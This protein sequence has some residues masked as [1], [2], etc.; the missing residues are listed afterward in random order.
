MSTSL[1]TTAS[2]MVSVAYAAVL[3]R[4]LTAAVLPMLRHLEICFSAEAAATDRSGM[5]REAGDQR[6]IPDRQ[7][8]NTPPAVAEPR[9]S[10]RGWPAAFPVVGWWLAPRNR[11]DGWILA[12]GIELL[13]AGVGGLAWWWEVGWGMQLPPAF[14][15]LPEAR[16]LLFLRLLA[17]LT[18]G[19]FLAAATWCDLRYRVIPDAITVPGLLLGMAA[20]TC[21]PGLLLPIGCLLPTNS[22]SSLVVPDLLGPAG[23]LL[24]QA[25]AGL[26]LDP[27][28]WGGL[29]L[30]AAGFVA[31]WSVGTAAAPHRRWFGD[32]RYLILA[33]G[34]IGI[35]A[36][37]RLAPADAVPT[38]L[39]GLTTSLAGAVG[40]GGLIVLTREAAS[41]ALGK[42]AMGL[43][44][45]TLMA[46][47]GSWLGWQVGVIAF[48]VAAF[49]GLAHGL[50]GWI[51][52]RENEL[53]FGPSLCLATVIVLVA[54]RWVWA[55]VEP[56][57]LYPLD[58]FVVLG[59]V[60]GLTGL[61]LAIWSR[62]RGGF[63][64]S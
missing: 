6:E 43:G 55:A 52:N 64:Q 22:A 40:A 45:A 9:W 63:G 51:W 31:W 24:C 3:G 36:T 44:D 18:L 8:D 60:V 30:L 50:L 34:L 7:E 54:W 26:L 33:G 13:A 15:D 37:W 41:R 5:R 1:D 10:R 25:Q 57:F 17:H 29:L 2:L 58:L 14:V 56:V 39:L 4:L 35:V 48:F 11:P 23:P 16:Q 38:N 19:G 32:P 49:L 28:S 46:M 47:A 62:L 53:A 12:A 20:V 27:R 61:T 42:E 59:V 21:W